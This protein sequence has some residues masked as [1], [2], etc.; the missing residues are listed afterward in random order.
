MK[1]RVFF[2]LVLVLFSLFTLRGYAH[3]VSFQGATSLMSSNREGETELSLH[4]SLRYWMSLGINTYKFPEQEATFLRTNFLLKRWNNPDSQGNIYLGVGHGFD[5]LK[6]EADQKNKVVQRS[7]GSLE[8]D[9]ESRKLYISGLHTQFSESSYELSRLR[10]GI[11]PYLADYNDLNTWF[12][13]QF[14]KVKGKDNIETTQFVRLFYRN[15]LIEIGAVYGGG[16]AL[17]LMAHF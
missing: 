5:R 2:Y 1:M 15:M 8:A 10:M 14:D 11:A 17:N 12:I 9:W 4:Y 6:D 16:F 13:V 3:P 7:M